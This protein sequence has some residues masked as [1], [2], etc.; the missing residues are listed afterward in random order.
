[1]PW[2]FYNSNGQRLSS[3]ATNISVLDIDGATDIGAAI[4]DAD[5]FIID[6]GAG[7]TNRKTAASR[8]K[9]YIPYLRGVLSLNVAAVEGTGAS[10]NVVQGR[11]GPAL[12]GDDSTQQAANFSFHMPSDFTTLQRA[13]LTIYTTSGSNNV[14]YAVYSYCAANG[15]IWNTSSDSIGNTTLS[16][17]DEQIMEIDVSS[18]LTN[19]A[20]SDHVQLVF[21]RNGSLGADTIS[22]LY[23]DGLILEWT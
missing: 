10:M 5:L 2:S 4:V 7:G 21:S 14:S 22:T 16:L 6:D 19:I 15:E 20:A 9:T 13:I 23:V 3:A 8:I 1:M 11:G 12:F 17:T 18:V